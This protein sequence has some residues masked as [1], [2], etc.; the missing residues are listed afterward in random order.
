M[1][2]D[3]SAPLLE[4]GQISRALDNRVYL[5]AGDPLPVGLIIAA[6]RLDLERRAFNVTQAQKDG[7]AEPLLHYAFHR[8][9]VRTAKS[10]IDLL[11]RALKHIERGRRS[12][13]R[14]TAALYAHA[15]ALMAALD[16]LR[17]VAA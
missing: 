9:D 4:W 6:A 15:S 13:K 12:G 17:G 14:S 11:S 2:E 1:S 10:D 7:D 5:T 3:S 8:D 16:T